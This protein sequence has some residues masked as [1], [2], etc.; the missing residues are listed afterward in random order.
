MKAD[1]AEELRMLPFVPVVPPPV[2]VVIV[3]VVP[4]VNV[5]VRLIPRCNR[6]YVAEFKKDILLLTFTILYVFPPPTNEA[7]PE[8]SR[9]KIE[10]VVVSVRLVAVPTFQVPEPTQFQTLLLISIVRTLEFEELSP[11]VVSVC[12]F[13]INDPFVTVKFPDIE[14]V[15]CNVHT[16]P[17][18]LNVIDVGFATDFPL[19]VMVF[20][21]DVEL[22]AILLGLNEVIVAPITRLPE[23]MI[24][25]EVLFRVPV[26]PV[27]SRVKQVA[28]VAIETVDAPELAS[29]N[30]LSDDVGTACPP[31]PPEVS[32]HF[33]PAV[34]SHES[35]PPTQYRDAIV[36][37]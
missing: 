20:P 36:L 22:N 5:T 12:P 13:V 32:A 1:P 16:P 31:A 23:I 2:K 6:V 26:N 15:S 28:V 3:C 37:D 10:L 27:V 18:P 4:A 30:T 9:F 7:M 34:A 17:T 29:M 24:P 19:L 33:V 8:V 25:P 21:E 14:K 35:V 11:K